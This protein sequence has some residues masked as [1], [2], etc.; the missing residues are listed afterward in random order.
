M[1]R[2]GDF[3]A[4]MFFVV[5]LVN[6][7]VYAILGWYSNLVAQGVI[8]SY[9]REVFDNM[10]RQPMS[11]FDRAENTTGALV[12][13]LSTEPQNLMELMS[14]NLSLIFTNII[15]L[16]SS[17]ILAIAVGWKLGLVLVFAALPPLVFSGYLRI[18]LEFKLD[19]DTAE[20]FAKSAGLAAEAV[21]AIRTVASLALERTIVDRFAASL[22][23]IAK[24]SIGR[25][26][27]TMFWY[28]LSQSMSFLSM[29]LGFW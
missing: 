23:N 3:W 22:T 13:R 1:T 24:S 2:R 17:C 11:F 19:E 28:A 29:G 4:L 14:Q 26:G 20:R 9:R 5:A 12:S 25:L 8:S 7:F 27:W 21:L 10:M 16:V 15:N 6:L 18:R